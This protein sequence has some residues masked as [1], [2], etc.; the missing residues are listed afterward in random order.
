M[1]KIYHI[2][3]NIIFFI[4]PYII[5]CVINNFP[6]LF[7]LFISFW[8]VFGYWTGFLTNKYIIEKR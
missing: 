6:V 5:C 8:I 2:I 3:A 7:S 4:L 1:K